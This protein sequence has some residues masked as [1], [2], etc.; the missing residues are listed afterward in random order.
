MGTGGTAVPGKEPSPPKRKRLLP[1]IPGITQL[2]AMDQ[3]FGCSRLFFISSSGFSTVE[4]PP[5]CCQQL[6][7]GPGEPNPARQVGCDDR[8]GIQEWV[9]PDQPWLWELSV[10]HLNPALS[11]G[12]NEVQ[13][14]F[15]RDGDSEEVGC[16]CLDSSHERDK[17]KVGF[18]EEQNSLG[19]WH[20][21]HTWIH[22]FPSTGMKLRLGF[23]EGAPGG[24]C[25]CPR[26]HTLLPQLCW[27]PW[28]GP[29]G[30]FWAEN[31]R[32]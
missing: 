17:A 30:S 19:S 21:L 11:S 16:G 28:L 20:W 15:W 32:F 26:T 7:D 10:A 18:L 8:S 5:P 25:Q 14:G 23:E 2:A 9:I 4:L 13:A 27:Q 3:L 22:P 31:R 24:G 6:R 1:G 29:S 12:R